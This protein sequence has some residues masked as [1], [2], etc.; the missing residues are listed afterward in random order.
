MELKITP[1]CKRRIAPLRNSVKRELKDMSAYYLGNAKKGWAKGSSYAD[2][3]QIGYAPAF[4]V[5]SAYA[6]A[7]TRVRSKDILPFL[8]WG[9]FT[10]SNPIVGMGLVGFAL[11][12]SANKLFKSIYSGITKAIERCM[13]KI[14]PHSGLEI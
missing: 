10:F 13:P 14:P 6:A 3:N 5:K 4:F 2:H 12:K 1:Y 8:G 7:G 9:F 11:G